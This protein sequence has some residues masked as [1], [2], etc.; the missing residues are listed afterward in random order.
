MRMPQ[1]ATR[2]VRVLAVLLLVA[3]VAAVAVGVRPCD[4]SRDVGSE[5]DP[6]GVPCD[7]SHGQAG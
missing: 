1:L 2:Y 4:S 3:G 5:K 6:Y 7:D